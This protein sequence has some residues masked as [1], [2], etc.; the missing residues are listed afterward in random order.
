VVQTKV[1]PL[2][3]KGEEGIGRVKSVSVAMFRGPF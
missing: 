2:S 3:A 1:P